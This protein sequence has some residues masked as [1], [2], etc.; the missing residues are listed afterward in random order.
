[1]YFDKEHFLSN[2]IQVAADRASEE[3]SACLTVSNDKVIVGV[4]I[5]TYVL[6]HLSMKKSMTETFA[7][8]IDAYPEAQKEILYA[9]RDFINENNWG[10]LLNISTRYEPQVF[11]AVIFRPF[12][13]TVKSASFSTPDSITRLIKRILDLNM[14]DRVADVGCGAGSFIVSASL[15]EPGAHYTGYEINPFYCAV[16]KIRAELLAAKIDINL[17]D[18]F[19]FIND[20]SVGARFN[21]VF[22][23][24]PFG[25][26]LRSSGTGIRYLKKLSEQFSG[27]SKATSSDWVFNSLLCDMLT[28]DGKAVGIMTNGSTWNSIDMPMRKHFVE[29]GMVEAVI[30]LPNRLFSTTNIA[31]SL[32]VLSHG[33]KFVRLIDASGICQQG[34][35]I[36]EFSDDNIEAILKL[37]QV[38]NDHS[39]AVSLEELRESE[40]T[41]NLS[42]YLTVCAPFSNGVPLESIIKSVS[43]GAYCTAKE[44]DKMASD[45]TTNMQY[46]MLANIRDGLI[47]EKLPYLASI[48]PQYLKYCLKDND[49]ILSKNGF[50]YKVAVASVKNG[51]QILA[52]G[53]LYIIEL[54]QEKVDPYYLKAFFESEQGIAALKSITVGATIPNI[55][56]EKLKKLLVPLPP[57]TEQKRIVEK[58]RSVLDEISILKSRLEKAVSHLHHVFDE[59]SEGSYA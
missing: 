46:L 52:S 35:R 36:N 14:D 41:L 12:N 25:L 39:K 57:L 7:E 16:A 58:Y 29:R 53:N 3:I 59:E 43:R 21:K 48:D 44:L 22:S 38:D 20:D 50:P 28:A 42:R 8:F 5:I 56:V 49:L 40:Y 6:Y 23:N 10:Q 9:A 17:Q 37:F 47:D 2:D 18:A 55:G 26:K 19:D 54:D 32:I 24:Y 4:P 45:A 11:V 51:Q 30:S 34:R 1:M 31:T 13:E 15:D 27:L 33:N